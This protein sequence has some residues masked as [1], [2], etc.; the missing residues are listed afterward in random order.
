MIPPHFFFKTALTILGHFHP[1]FRVNLARSTKIEER[2]FLTKRVLL[3]SHSFLILWLKEAGFF[4]FSCLFPGCSTL[5]LSETIRTSKES[6]CFIVQ[7]PR[8]LGSPPSSRSSKNS[9][10]CLFVVLYSGGLRKNE[11]L[12][13][14]GSRNSN[15][16]F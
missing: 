10:L 4:F 15:V 2:R 9:F 1:D 14:D 5:V 12:I 11:V 3:Y 13:I 8:A 7:V 6:Q 16:Y